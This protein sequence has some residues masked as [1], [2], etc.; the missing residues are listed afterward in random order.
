MDEIESAYS[1]LDELKRLST[2]TMR[3]VDFISELLPTHLKVD[4]RRKYRDLSPL[5]LYSVPV[6]HTKE[7]R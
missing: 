4:W 7:S 5:G 6:K 2:L 3:D 1:Q